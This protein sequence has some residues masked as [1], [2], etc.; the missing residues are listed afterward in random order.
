VDQGMPQPHGGGTRKVAIIVIRSRTNQVEDLLPLTD[1]VIAAL[2][3]IKP[4]EIV[5]I[6]EPE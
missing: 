5:R 1:A 6:P 4:G 2:Q 3:S